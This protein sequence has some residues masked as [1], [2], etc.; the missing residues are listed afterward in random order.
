MPKFS[1]T[2]RYLKNK[3]YLSSFWIS[4]VKKYRM[5]RLSNEQIEWIIKAKVNGKFTNKEIADVQGIS[6]SRVQQLYREY[7]SRKLRNIKGLFLKAINNQIVELHRKYR[8]NASY[9][10]KFSEREDYTSEMKKSINSSWRLV[11][12]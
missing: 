2:L 7:K 10:A 5:R 8:I 9:M 12:Q 3:S 6:I 11:L 4:I 1:H